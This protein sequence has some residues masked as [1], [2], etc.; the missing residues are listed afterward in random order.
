ML[1][2]SARTFTARAAASSRRDQVAAQRSDDRVGDFVLDR[3]D[4]GQLA[5]VGLRPQVTVVHR[6][7]QLRGDAHVVAGLAHA[8]FEDV[9]DLER[10]RDVGRAERTALVRER[11]RA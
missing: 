1:S 6:V 9:V 4:V 3:E 8:A 11:R 7:D 2:V 10:L 5:I